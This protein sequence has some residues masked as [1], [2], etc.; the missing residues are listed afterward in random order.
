MR[1]RFFELLFDAERVGGGAR[2]E[3]PQRI[4]IA[5]P[6]GDQ[7]PERPPLPPNRSR[8]SRVRGPARHGAQRDRVARFVARCWRFKVGRR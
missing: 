5:R 4:P 1:Q 2:P 6:P 8:R 3:F 7:R